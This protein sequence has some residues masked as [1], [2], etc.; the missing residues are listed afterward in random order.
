MIK[1]E[2]MEAQATHPKDVE[3]DTSDLAEPKISAPPPP[4]T[5]RSAPSTR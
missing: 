4:P 5:V 1:V 3:M 2:P